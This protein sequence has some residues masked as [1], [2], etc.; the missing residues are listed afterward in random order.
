M[1]D[2]DRI[3]ELVDDLNR[4][5]T[6]YY[7]YDQPLVTDKVYD[8]LYDE[9]VRLE[10]ETGHILEYSPTQRVGDRILEKFDKHKHL[11]QL[12]SLDKA[13]NYE[14]LRNWDK[15]LRKTIAEYNLR[16]NEKFEISYCLEFKFD[17]LT[18]NLTYDGGLLVQGATRGNGSIGESILPQIKAIRSIPLRISYKGL[19][20][21]QGEGLMPLT[22]LLAY[23]E[24][25]DDQLKNARNAAAGALRNLDPRVTE[26]RK[27]KAYFYNVGYIE[28]L[29][30]DNHE[31]MIQFIKD[32]T[33][34]VFDYLQ[35][36][37]DIEDVILEIE[38]IKDHRHGL[39]ILTDG[40]V[41]KIDDI[42]AREALGYTQKFPK[43]AIA[44]KFEAEEVMTV[45][46]GV[47]WN[48]GRTGKVTPT[49]LLEPVDIGGVTVKRAT[50]N[51]IDDIRRKN[52]K[53]NAVVWLRRSNDVIPEIL[54]TVEDDS[55]ETIEIDMPDKCP[56]CGTKL[57]QEGVHYFCVNKLSCKPQLIASIVHFASRDAMNIEGFS[58]KTAEQFVDQLDLKSISDIY[59]LDKDILLTLERFGD[60]KADNLIKAI[61]NSKKCKLNHLIY[62]LGIPNVGIKTATDLSDCF[63][64][65]EGIK[66]AQY[67]ELT[68]IPDVGEVVANSVISFFN[69]PKIQDDIDKLFEYGVDPEHEE[70]TIKESFLTNKNVVITGSLSMSRNEIINKIG[71]M[72]GNVVGSVS[73]KTDYV[74]AGENPG[75]K[76]DKALVLNIP[77][78]REEDL[79][80]IFRI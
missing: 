30:F 13:Q 76:L 31:E 60:K 61:E 53:I 40:L 57:I 2:I 78:L 45:L 46:R 19:M 24:K 42:K 26:K 55:Q 69:N 79:Q 7:T 16:N 73:K 41:I 3:V 1:N 77:I 9:L 59:S 39:D 37:K 15:R 70:K 32:Q 36:F 11:R 38:R 14:E 52:V 67:E 35:S 6:H 62:A 8:L 54:G 56:Y 48:V 34:P 10:N 71:S 72:G 80:E 23:N 47:V 50:L 33:L 43:W 22:S 25:N 44:Y 68:A 17:G 63:K 5:A 28:G 27:L 4:Y 12:W 65:Y 29:A 75:S 58:E 49:A 20:E 21:V 51:N 64:S 66:N 18:I 74:I